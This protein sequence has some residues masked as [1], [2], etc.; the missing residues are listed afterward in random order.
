LL[1]RRT[2]MPHP[3]RRLSRACM[4][5][6]HVICDA[7]FAGEGGRRLRLRRVSGATRDGGLGA[8]DC[9]SLEIAVLESRTDLQAAR[10]TQI[11]T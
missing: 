4:M 7:A 2:L 3:K 1:N 6:K 10:R 8:R 11:S 5:C 9:L